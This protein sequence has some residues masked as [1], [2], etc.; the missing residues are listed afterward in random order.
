MTFIRQATIDDAIYVGTH[1]QDA[2]KAELDGLGCFDHPLAVEVS[3]RGSIDPI[4]FF[5]PD[6]KLC[7]VAGVSRVSDQIGGIWMLTT[8][9]VR[10]H[11][12]LFLSEAKKWVN[13]QTDFDVLANIADPRNRL[14]MKLLHLLGFKRLS[15]QVVGPRRLTYVEFAK[16][17]SCVVSQQ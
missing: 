3:V 1:L 6:D 13:K 16:L 9:H 8:D 15:Y 4:S 7:G 10:S 5:T 11:P 17:T 2:D 12:K 14:H